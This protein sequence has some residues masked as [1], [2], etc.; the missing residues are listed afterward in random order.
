MLPAYPNSCRV[1]PR[2]LFYFLFSFHKGENIICKKIKPSRTVL[3]L[4]SS[5]EDAVLRPGEHPTWLGL[6]HQEKAARDN[7]GEIPCCGEWRLPS[8]DLNC[9]PWRFA[10]CQWLGSKMLWKDCQGLSGPQA[11]TLCCS[12]T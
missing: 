8:A 3:L 11:S 6:S 1:K 7:S 10:A 5:L 9:H 2:A 4:Q 12:S